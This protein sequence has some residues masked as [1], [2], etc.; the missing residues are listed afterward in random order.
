VGEL[1]EERP[2]FLGSRRLMEEQGLKVGRVLD[3]AAHAAEAAGQSLAWVGWD[4]RARGLFAF[5]ERLRPSVHD[6]LAHCRVLGLDVGVLTGDHAARG[7]ALSRVLSV[8]VQAGL[9]P[10]DK[11]AAIQSARAHFG[12]VAMVGDGIN[13]APALA[14]SDLGVAL[15]CGTDLS[16]ES[17]AIC[18]LGDDLARFPWAVELSRRTVG[19]VRGNLAWAFGY[20]AV[21]VAFAA[22]GWLSPAFAAFLMVGSSALVIVNSLRLRGSETGVL[23]PANQPA[24]AHAKPVLEGAAA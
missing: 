1:D 4:G 19:V 21:G 3:A 12:A 20:N 11:V 6:A 2:T 15:G 16:R 13:D 14:A 23:P 22:A 7:A 24:L 18:L 8:P 9:L 5:D 10:E 17:A